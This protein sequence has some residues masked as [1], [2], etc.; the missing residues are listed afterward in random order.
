MLAGL[1]KFLAV[2]CGLN[3]IAPSANRVV[4]FSGITT[5]YKN[6]LAPLPSRALAGGE[7]AEPVGLTAKA[8]RSQRKQP[9]EKI[10]ASDR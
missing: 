2:G 7:G 9:R 1:L 4:D 8:Q 5:L 10:A 6:R 3:E